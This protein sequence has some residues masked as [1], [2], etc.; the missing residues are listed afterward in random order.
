MAWKNSVLKEIV[1][2]N[3]SYNLISFVIYTYR[4]NS[5]NG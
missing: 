4:E 2:K 1:S 5:P 3:V